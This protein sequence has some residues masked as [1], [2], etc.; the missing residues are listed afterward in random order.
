[1]SFVQLLYNSSVNADLREE[2]MR[3]LAMIKRFAKFLVEFAFYQEDN[4]PVSPKIIAAKNKLIRELSSEVRTTRV[5][6]VQNTMVKSQERTRKVLMDYL[7]LVNPF[8][9]LDYIFCS[10][11]TSIEIQSLADMRKVY[12]DPYL[13]Y[14]AERK[15]IRTPQSREKAFEFYERLKYKL[16]VSNIQASIINNTV[17]GIVNNAVNNY[18]NIAYPR[19]PK[20]ENEKQTWTGGYGFRKKD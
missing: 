10:S 3:N 12:F 5:S 14:N 4:M 18:E 20:Q 13:L 1:M 19:T 9:G 6:R 17:V 16:D 11:N 2:E 7:V 15:R 8:I